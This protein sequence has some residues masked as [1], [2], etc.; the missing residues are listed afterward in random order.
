MIDWI[1]RALYIAFQVVFNTQAG[2]T[3]ILYVLVYKV[4]RSIGFA[5]IDAA[6]S[7]LLLVA[8]AVN[9]LPL[10]TGTGGDS[11]R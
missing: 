11:D 4:Y 3:T 6:W 7:A 8:V 5:M 1:S 10:F 9:L 2:L